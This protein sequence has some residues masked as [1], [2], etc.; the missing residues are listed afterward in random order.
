MC[1][2][3]STWR[4]RKWLIEPRFFKAEYNG[5]IAAP[6]TPNAQVTPSF[7][8]TRTAASI[9][10]I[11]AMGQP[12]V[13]VNAERSSCLRRSISTRSILFPALWHSAGIRAP[14][15]V[16]SG[17][18]KWNR[19]ARRKCASRLAFLGR[20][21]HDAPER[22]GQL[23]RNLA[24]DLAKS[25]QPVVGHAAGHARHGNR[26]KRFAAIVVDHGGDASQP[27]TRFLIIDGVTLSP[28]RLKFPEQFAGPHD[29]LFRQPRHALAADD[30]LDVLIRIGGE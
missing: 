4:A 7:S 23:I 8:R 12:L 9:A 15:Q 20:N 25:G 10:R 19:R 17:K 24:H 11:F 6:G 5:L 1:E 30:R 2:A 3:P 18:K 22:N 27:H 29:R 13:C 28:D 26:R 21:R 14:V 16:I